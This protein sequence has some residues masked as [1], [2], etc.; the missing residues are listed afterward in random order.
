[1]TRSSTKRARRW[2]LQELDRID[3]RRDALPCEATTQEA[4]TQGG[5]S[6]R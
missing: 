6:W 4:T 3:R 2:I 1:M 5:A